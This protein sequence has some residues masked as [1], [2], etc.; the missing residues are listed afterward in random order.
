MAQGSVPNKTNMKDGANYAPVGKSEVVVQPGEFTFS[1]A[2]LDHG[3]INGQTNG[4]LQAGA[5]L[6]YVYDS[7]EARLAAFCA[8]YPQA[9]V[10]DS[11]QQILDD[12]DTKLVASAAI[13]HLRAD[14]GIRVMQAGKDYFTD[15]SP[16]TTLDQLAKVKEVVTHTKQKYAVYYAERLHNE[17]AWQAGELIKQG[18]IGRVLQVVNLAPHRLAKATRPDWFFDKHC[19][20]G[21]LTDIGSHQVEQFLTYAGETNASINFSRVENFNNSDKPGLEDFGEISMTGDNGTSFYTRVDWFT[22]EGQATWGDGR[23]IIIGT[24]G[25][26]ECRKYN[27]VAR[28]AP[29]SKLFFTNHD[30]EQEIDCLGQSSF[31]YFGQLILDVINRTENAM[32]QEHVF[33]AA[34]LSMR[35]Q[36]M[37]DLAKQ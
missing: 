20:G 22:P 16:F 25:N 32:S 10:A 6:K 35:A 23:T 28:Q 4:L 21:I 19:Y 36:K 17:A 13:P 15:K 9:T 12:S 37:A 3:H 26:I 29:A 14:I 31:P 30:K 7:N 33:K 5:T 2:Y 18:A 34:E 24:Q 27:D 11:F 1:V 8:K